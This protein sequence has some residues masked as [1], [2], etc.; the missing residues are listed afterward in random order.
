MPGLRLKGLSRWYETEPVPP[1]GQPPYINGVALLIGSIDP[2]AF[3][4]ALQ[5]IEN[6]FGRVRGEPNAARTLDLDIVA[7]GDLVRAVPDPIVPHPRAHARAFVLAPLADV[8][9]SW[10]HPLLGR[11]AAEILAE[12]PPQGIRVCRGDDA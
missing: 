2:A 11:T 8:A 6:A 7:M 1:S 10:V 5:R 12:L 3:L 9:P 4:T